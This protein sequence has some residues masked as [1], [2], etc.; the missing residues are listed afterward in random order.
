MTIEFPNHQIHYLL[1][2]IDEEPAEVRNAYFV[3]LSREDPRQ[4]EWVYFRADVRDDFEQLWGAVPE[5]YSSLRVLFRLVYE[6]RADG[7]PVEADVY[8]DDLY[9]G[10]ASADP[11]QPETS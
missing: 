6:D 2:G 3:F 11:N 10:P 7:E 1:A 8:F 4:D 9:L 5:G